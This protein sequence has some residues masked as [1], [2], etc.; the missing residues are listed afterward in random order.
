MN[1]QVKTIELGG[2]S[3]PIYFGLI[4]LADFCEDRNIA[5]GDFVSSLQKLTIGDILDLA[6]LGLK[7]GSEAK[8]KEFSKDRFEVS[9][10]LDQTEGS[11]VQIMNLLTESMMNI[12][13]GMK[14]E[15][16]KDEDE[17]KPRRAKKA[18]ASS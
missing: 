4:T 10:L 12:Q 18:K 9:F 5:L 1:I 3:C 16:V 2:E 6:V 17:K 15:G 13:K 8:G 14:E 7:Y 11:L